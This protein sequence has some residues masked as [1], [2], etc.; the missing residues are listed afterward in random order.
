[1]A[2][3]EKA[4]KSTDILHETH[5]SK[6]FVRTS[7]FK[8]LYLN[9]INFG[10]TRFDFQMVLGLVEISKAENYEAVVHETANVKMT[11]GYA[12]AL[13]VDLAAALASY[14]TKYG[15]IALPPVL[16]P[17]AKPGSELASA[18]RSK[19]PK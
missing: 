15:E 14:E 11:P 13:V 18:A 3:P 6:R 10:F 12:K 2:S 4:N 7:D 19:K 1:M 5:E 9:N 16:E 8:S 17:P